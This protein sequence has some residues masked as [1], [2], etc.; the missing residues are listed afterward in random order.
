MSFVAPLMLAG[1]AAVAV[2]VLIHLIGRR[3]APRVP[4]AAIAFLRASNRRVARRVRL[5]HL[6][7]LAL[8]A[9]LVAAAAVMA[10][11]PFVERESDL[12]A[13]GAGARAVALVVDDTASM[14]ARRDGRSLFSRAQ[15]AAR[16]L[17]RQLGPAAQVAVLS[18][19][20][21][22]GPL[23]RLSADPRRIA[24]A[25]DGLRPTYR[26]A[27]AAPAVARAWR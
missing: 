13:L 25:I 10:A 24:A 3:R 14:R 12:P 26:H 15:E 18:L 19:S 4:F 8:R 2:P 7:L 22:S 17:V 1:V 21:P 5:R 6:L 23:A 27:R 9:G 16:K 20:R 11:Q